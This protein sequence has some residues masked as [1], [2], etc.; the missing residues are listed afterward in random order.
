MSARRSP[1]RRNPFDDNSPA[2]VANDIYGPSAPEL[3][4]GR[5][6]ATPVPIY[7]IVPDPRQP[8]RAIPSAV[9]AGKSTLGASPPLF[10]TWALLAYC[11]TTGTPLT[12]DVKRRLYSGGQVEDLYRAIVAGDEVQRPENPGPIERSLLMV[13]DLAADI[14]TLGT[15]TNPITIAPYPN[16][17]S[18]DPKWLIET[19]ERR[20]LAYHMLSA[21][22][23]AGFDKIPAQQVAFNVWRQASENNQRSDLNSISRARQFAILLMD[24]LEE[25]GES[26]QPLEAFEREQDYYAQIADA[27][28]P[29][30]QTERILGAMGIKS[31]SMLSDYRALLKLPPDLWIKGDDESWPKDDLAQ[32]VRSTNNNEIVTTGDEVA[33]ELGEAVMV[34][35]T[36]EI[37]AVI[38][39]DSDS[40]TVAIGDA[41][42]DYARTD[43]ASLGMSFEEFIAQETAG[44]PGIRYGEYADAEDEPVGAAAAGG[45]IPNIPSSPTPT[46]PAPAGPG[47]EE[48]RP[49]PLVKKWTPSVNDIVWLID[50]GMVG[51]VIWLAPPRQAHVKT[52]GGSVRKCSFDNLRLAT[53]D[54]ISPPAADREFVSVGSSQTSAARPGSGMKLVTKDDPAHVLL[55]YCEA[56]ATTYHDEDALKLVQELRALT[57]GDVQRRAE[58]EDLESVA[59]DY[60]AAMGAAMTRW[61]D[62]P[63]YTLL[64]RMMTLGKEAGA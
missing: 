56:I 38:G 45:H 24:L 16:R 35:K 15:L 60:Y 43:L 31:R 1:D 59:S 64:K 58:T 7:D 3:A 5:I 14:R 47:Y 40:V 11:E 55:L 62:G 10:L 41:E 54:E 27:R 51:K 20:Y 44:D 28:I 25:A 34:R 52:K 39:W 30:G 18:T 50:P 4:T 19:G 46:T 49:E 9:R 53:P 12:P 37:G 63:F 32:I 2:A 61:L 26:F 29:T 48:G 42:I 17:T 21:F 22:G 8:R 33:F 57:V 36:E 13:A 23:V 6:V